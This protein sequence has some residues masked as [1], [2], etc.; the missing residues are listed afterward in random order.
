[1]KGVENVKVCRRCHVQKPGSE[2]YKNGPRL[3]SRCKACHVQ[4]VSAYKRSNRGKVHKWAVV[5]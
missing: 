1:M 5:G 3:A 2:F 4:K